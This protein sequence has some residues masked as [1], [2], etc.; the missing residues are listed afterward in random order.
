MHRRTPAQCKTKEND[1]YI[2]EAKAREAS[3][4]AARFNVTEL[5]HWL[6]LHLAGVL[7]TNT[8]KSQ[9]GCCNRRQCSSVPIIWGRQIHHICQNQILLFDIDTLET[10]SI[11]KLL[12]TKVLLNQI[13]SESKKQSKYEFAVN[14]VLRLTVHFGLLWWSITD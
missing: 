4:S 10:V 12:L 13:Q 3:P 5:F 8:L 11:R 1:Q 7:C 2:I 6:K 14:Y 9:I